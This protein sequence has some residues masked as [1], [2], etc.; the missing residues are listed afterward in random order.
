MAGWSMRLLQAEVC[1]E[2]ILFQ[3][4]IGTDAGSL[5]TPEMAVEA[6]CFAQGSACAFNHG[7]TIA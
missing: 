3:V 6:M 7:G 5:R 2:S 4:K 1:D